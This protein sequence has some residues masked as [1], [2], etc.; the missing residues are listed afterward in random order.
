MPKNIGYQD[1][2]S[3]GSFFSDYVPDDSISLPAFQGEGLTM[4]DFIEFGTPSEVRNAAL[5]DFTGG[6]KLEEAAAGATGP[7]IITQV[8][9]FRIDPDIQDLVAHLGKNISDIGYDDF[10]QAGSQLSRMGDKVSA[11]L[12]EAI[13]GVKTDVRGFASDFSSLF[14]GG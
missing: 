14:F 9:E 11:S 2:D 4:R 1:F 12:D 3:V 5:A 13:T 6:K 8:P 10:V 7:E